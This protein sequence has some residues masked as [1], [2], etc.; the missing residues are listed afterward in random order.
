MAKLIEISDNEHQTAPVLNFELTKSGAEEEP[1]ELMQQNL[2]N[3]PFEGNLV[4]PQEPLEEQEEPEEEESNNYEGLD[5]FLGQELED[6]LD[7]VKFSL[8]ITKPRSTE[9]GTWSAIV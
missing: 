2:L 6:Y 8:G 3:K 5:R 1:E 7:Q 9:G 4:E